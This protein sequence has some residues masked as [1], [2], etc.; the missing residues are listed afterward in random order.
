MARRS[1]DQKT[2]SDRTK[3]R[4]FFAEVDGSNQSVQEMMRALTVVMD[5]SPQIVGPQQFLQ[6]SQPSAGDGKVAPPAKPDTVDADPTLE[7]DATAGTSEGSSASRRRRGDGP[8]TDRNARLELV[9]DLDFIPDGKAS[10]KAFMAEK[11]PAN[12]ME[13]TLVL[14]HY[15]QHT[16]ELAE[17]GANHILTA[18]KH[19]GVP[20]PV[21][22]RG[23]IR[24]M[25][26]QKAW[27][28]W[29]KPDSVRVTT[30]GENVVEH[31][32]PRTSGKSGS[33]PK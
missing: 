2:G 33:G 13:Q 3:V 4:V 16:L 5:R 30:E 1:A 23:T 25:K 17:Y 29:S 9:R 18:F 28:N 21:D 6:I 8:K 11:A 32:L 31:E 27:L 22:L 15:L 20:V 19:V 26:R 10:L 14:A 24:N 12:D 7:V